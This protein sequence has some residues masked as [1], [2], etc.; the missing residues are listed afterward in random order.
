MAYSSGFPIWKDAPFIRITLPF[1][2]GIVCQWYW[3]M[4]VLG[5]WCIFIISNATRC[6]YAV[7]SLPIQYYAQWWPGACFQATLFCAGSLLCNYK[8]VNHQRKCITSTYIA[9]NAVLVTINEPLTEKPHSFKTIATV[10]AVIAHDSIQKATGNF[11]L[12]FEKDSSTQQLRYGQQLVLHSPLQPVKNTGNP[13]CFDYQRYCLFQGIVYQSYVKKEAF[14]SLT[15]LNENHFQQWLYHTRQRIVDILKKYIPG[16]KEAGLAEAMLIGYKDDLDKTLVQSYSNTGVVHIIAISGLHLGLVYWLLML[17]SKSIARRRSGRLLQTI[18]VIGGL[19]LFSCMVGGSP[20]VLRSAVMF[21]CLVIGTQINRKIAIYNS[22][23]ASAFLLLCY[24]PFWLWDAGFQLSY[25]A[26]LSLAI[27]VKPIYNCIFI[28][29]RLLNLVWQS[30]AVT[31]AAQILTIP[32]SV[33]L[34]HQ[35]PNLFVVTNLLAVPLSSLVIMGEIALCATSIFPPAAHA[36]GYCL[37]YIIHWLNNFIEHIGQ[38]PFAVWNSLQIDMIQVIC[39]YIFIAG[40]AWWLLRTSKAG[41]HVS[42]YAGLLFTSYNTITTWIATRQ[43]TLIVYN[44]PKHS[45]IDLFEGGY[46]IYKGDSLLQQ[47][48][49][50]R[51]FYLQ[52][53]R[54]VHRVF[55][56]FPTRYL[57]GYDNLF[58]VGNR[59]ILVIKK[60]TV[61]NK[62]DEKMPVD[63]IVLSDNA[64]VLITGLTGVFACRQFVFDAS[65]SLKRVAAWQRECV[66]LGISGFSVAEHGA[67]V[68]NG[69]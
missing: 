15:T 60:S 40:L 43:H 20:S 30:T 7:A 51:N 28:K 63:V 1:I 55:T 57:L 46:Y 17:L 45:A 6:L 36:I 50:M 19:W 29:N 69:Y 3:P 65:N 42:L 44:V 54:L 34:F 14:V 37:Q 52:P 48:A 33:Y 49:E 39:L 16:K 53:C 27:F 35:F 41:I 66:E 24:N 12:Y 58:W 9:E 10:Q 4:P 62:G 11:L 22:L 8:D 38:L 64:P 56:G 68:L 32:V 59:S 13:G 18:I 23:A 31:L 25:T 67:F 21:S 26:V 61:L 2:I 47:D 5:I